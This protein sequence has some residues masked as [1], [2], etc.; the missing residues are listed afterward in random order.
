L[1]AAEHLV[2]PRLLDVQDLALERQDRLKAAIAPLLGRPAG[3]FAFDDVELAA[4]GIALLAVG[5]LAGQR[6]AVEGPFAAHEIARLPRRFTGAG[7]IDRLAQNPARPR[8]I[9]F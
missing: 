9:L 6:A 2:E 5:E 3:R 1:V 4:R 8:R 7:G